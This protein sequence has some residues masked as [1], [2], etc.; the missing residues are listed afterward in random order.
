MRIH[1]GELCGC[2]TC[3]W[4]G[5]F[6]SSASGLGRRCTLGRYTLGSARSGAEVAEEAQDGVTAG[7]LSGVFM[8]GGA[9]LWGLSVLHVCTMYN[10][11]LSS[12]LF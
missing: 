10:S 7:W 3:R 9:R 6:R 12:R 1:L 4:N 5:G 2:V 8:A 11:E